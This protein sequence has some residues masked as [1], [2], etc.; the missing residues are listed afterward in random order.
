MHKLWSVWECFPFMCSMTFDSF[1]LLRTTPQHKHRYICESVLLIIS[2]TFKSTSLYLQDT[3]RVRRGEVGRVHQILNACA[4]WYLTLTIACLAA[5][6][7]I[8]KQR[9]VLAYYIYFILT[10]IYMYL[11][12]ICSSW[13]VQAALFTLNMNISRYYRIAGNFRGYKCFFAYCE[14]FYTHEFNAACMH[15]CY[16]AK[17][18]SV[19]TFLIFPQKFIT[20]KIT[21][22]TVAEII[23]PGGPNIITSK[24][25][26]NADNI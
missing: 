18:K 15:A 21:R 5:C 22:Y 17:I 24:V 12:C 9:I 1:E 8:Y 7:A 14:H 2:S 26:T 25:F 11:P 3:R 4:A 19:K 23:C 6:L 10:S 20:T 13:T 16:S